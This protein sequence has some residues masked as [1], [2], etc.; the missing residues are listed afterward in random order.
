MLIK[1]VTAIIDEAQL[2]SVENALKSHGVT[3]FTIYPVRGRGSYSNTFSKD[4]L[5]AH[6]QIVL[7]T[8]EQYVNQIAKLIMQTA[9]VGTVD[10]GLVAI[11]PV[12]QLFWVYKKTAVTANEFQYYELDEN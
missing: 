5:V 3:G 12:D 11:S 2:E 4:G 6:I 7:Y 8:S 10:E 9:D 1:K